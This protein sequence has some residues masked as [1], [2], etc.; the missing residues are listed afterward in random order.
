MGWIKPL[1]L[2]CYVSSSR[3]LV[4][5]VICLLRRSLDLLGALVAVINL[6]TG[7]VGAVTLWLLGRRSGGV[8]Q[9][10]PIERH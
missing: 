9:T 2:K 1:K 6:V 8:L 4:Y 3:E 10:K 5:G 7:S